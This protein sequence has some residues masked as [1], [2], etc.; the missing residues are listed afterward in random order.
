MIAQI[1]PTELAAW[2]ADAA[3]PAPVVIDVREAWEYERCHIGDT[4]HIPLREIPARI[5]EIPADRELVLMCHHGGRSLQAAGWL[6][7]QGFTHLHS[8]A[9]GI[10][11]WARTVDPAMPRY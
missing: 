3:R 5:S 11:A 7:Q 9:G 4:Q 10:D 6:A 2:R 8:L 1:T